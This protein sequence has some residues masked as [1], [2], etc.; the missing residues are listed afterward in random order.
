MSEYQVRSASV[1]GTGMMGPG[2]AVILA[3]GGVR[4]AILSR[5]GTGAARGLEKARELLEILAAAGLTTAHEAKR[6]AGLV[7][8]SDA[9]DETIAASGLVVESGPENMAWKQELFA[10][11]DRL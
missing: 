2:I 9:F 3:L 6:A 8:G 1:I 5:T 4:T 11:M 10:R 7:A